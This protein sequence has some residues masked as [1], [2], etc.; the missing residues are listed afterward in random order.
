MDEKFNIVF[1]LQIKFCPIFSLRTSP[2]YFID[3]NNGAQAIHLDG[4]TKVLTPAI[5]VVPCATYHFKIAIVDAGDGAVDSA[6]MLEVVECSA[7]LTVTTSSTPASCGMSDGTASVVL[8]GGIGPFTYSWSPV[9]GTGA[10]ATNLPAGT[11]IVKIDDGVTCSPPRYDTIIV[12][13]ANTPVATVP[14]NKQVCAGSNIPVSVFTSSMAGATI[15]WTNTTPAIGLAASGTGNAPSFMATNTGTTA[16]T[17]TI[18]VTAT[19]NG[20]TSPP[21]SFTITV[22]PKPDISATGSTIC[23]GSPGTLT[24]AGASTYTWSPVTVPATGST[25]VASPTVSTTYTVIGQN[26]FGCADTSLALLNVSPSP[27]VTATAT[28][29]CQGETSMITISGASSYNWPAGIG[30][31]AQGQVVASPLTTT[32]YTVVGTTANCS[33]TVSIQVVVNP[34]PVI[35]ATASPP[36]ICTGLSSNLSATGAN[37]YT[38]SGGGVNTIGSSLQVSPFTTTTYTVIGATPNGC[39]DTTTVTVTVSPI[40][41][42]NAGPDTLINCNIRTANLLATTAI[43]NAVYSW[44]GP[45]GF[46]AVTSAI[47]V[48][49]GGQYIITVTDPLTG[50]K[51]K[52]TVLVKADT[53]HPIADISLTG[54]YCFTNSITLN[55]ISTQQNSLFIWMGPQNFASNGSSVTVTAEGTYTLTTANP[56]NGCLGKDTISVYLNP[57]VSTKGAEICIGERVTLM[58]SGA[59]T[60]NWSNGINNQASIQVSPTTTTTYTVTGINSRGCEDTAMAQVLVNPLPGASF[61]LSANE[62]SELEPFTTF[63][64]TT[65]INS[66]FYWT[67]DKADTIKAIHQVVKEFKEVGEHEICLYAT[68][69]KGCKDYTCNKLKV[70]PVWAIYFPNAFSPNSDNWND[71][72]VPDGFNFTNFEM[73]IYDRWGNLVF[74][75]ND[76]KKTWDGKVKDGYSA[77]TSQQDVFIYKAKLLD[78]LKTKREYVGKISLVR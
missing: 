45:Q 28:P 30:S 61:S 64:N 44:L 27:V 49:M 20:C 12:A 43:P 33:D 34:L 13:G 60:Y 26:T 32:T 8:S 16:L 38:W 56:I 58:A 1:F 67:I 76:I 41:P 35:A 14:A 70:E 29:I 2:N 77:A 18:S 7:P 36:D 46:N 19:L 73:W 4:F 51:S 39:K 53:L 31:N 25:V 24:A 78:V 72:Y 11:Y 75:T 63:T 47:T 71:T 54:S 40:L 66:T 6:V 17:A 10:T 15:N 5:D 42:V 74:Y 9:G 22:N 48:N 21:V 57:V 59:I 37:T 23:A 55:G 3:N 62:L 50:C 65:A 68:T 69:A 52:D